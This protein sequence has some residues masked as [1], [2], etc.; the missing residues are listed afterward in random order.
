[1]LDGCGPI[2]KV[3]TAARKEN[4]LISIT[5]ASTTQ[6]TGEKK[7]ARSS[8]KKRVRKMRMVGL[9]AFGEFDKHI[10]QAGKLAVQFAN[11]PVLLQRQ[12][13]DG[14]ANVG[15]GLDAKGESFPVAIGLA[16]GD[17]AHPADFPKF[18]LEW[19]LALEFQF[20]VG[21]GAQFAHQIARA[22]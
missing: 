11:V 12:L 3:A 18:L 9:F 20:D 7:S 15:P 17:L 6:A 8:L 22:V 10:L 14:G 21:H 13:E 19:A 1:M 4:P 16:L 2:S 5:T